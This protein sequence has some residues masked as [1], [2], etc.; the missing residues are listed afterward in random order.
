[1]GRACTN[2]PHP[3][4][5]VFTNFRYSFPDSALKR[6]GGKLAQVAAATYR[7]SHGGVTGGSKQTET[8]QR[9]SSEQEQ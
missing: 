4:Q 5:D 1:M 8:A 3:Q 7:V 2:R 9:R 6:N